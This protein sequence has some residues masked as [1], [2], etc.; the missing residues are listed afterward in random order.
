MYRNLLFNLWY[1]FK[2]PWDTGISPPELIE[3][4]A[5]HPPGRALDLGCGSGTNV[6]TLSQSGWQVTGIDFARR[7]ILTARK[8]AKR[9][10]VKAEFFIGDVTR[11]EHLQD[12]FELILDIGCFHMLPDQGK[13]RY[14][15]HLKRLLA[16]DGTYMMYGFLS[17]PTDQGPGLH[18]KDLRRISEILT[19]SERQDGTEKGRKPSAWFFF[20]KLNQG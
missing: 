2:P 13:S 8:K 3:F 14:L 20:T 12:S 5:G 18:E 6:I 10:M 19:L 1:F 4:I 11:L 16:Q 17:S 7:A 15:E 9:A